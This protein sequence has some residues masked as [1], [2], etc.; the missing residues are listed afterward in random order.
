MHK[1]HRCHDGLP[2]KNWVFQDEWSAAF[3]LLTSVSTSAGVLPLRWRPRSL[4]S[5]CF[6]SSWQWDGEAG[7][8][9][10]GQRLPV[11]ASS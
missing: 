9:Q 3:D 11:S 6:W 1:D 5:P 8:S 2:G 4:V 10:P 7:Q